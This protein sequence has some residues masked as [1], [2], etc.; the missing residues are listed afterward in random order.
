MPGST[1]KRTRRKVED[2][3]PPPRSWIVQPGQI[4]GY[5]MGTFRRAPITDLLKKAP[6]LGDVTPW[7]TADPSPND[8]PSWVNGGARTPRGLRGRLRA[9]RPS[10][11]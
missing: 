3:L 11:Q 10:H 4:R 1:T 2:E 5:S 8:V 9:L 7:S 6:W